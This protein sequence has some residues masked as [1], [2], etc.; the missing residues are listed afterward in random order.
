VTT[1]E[2]DPVDVAAGIRLT[3]S[4][5]LVVGSP[6]M[7]KPLLPPEGS[8][9]CEPVP[10]AMGGGDEPRL[11]CRRGQPETHIQRGVEEARVTP[12]CPA[13]GRTGCPRQ[14]RL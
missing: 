4:V 11:E 7:G 6:C 5:S 12:S 8:W 13:Y 3:P 14:D 1:A 9:R 10:R 2:H